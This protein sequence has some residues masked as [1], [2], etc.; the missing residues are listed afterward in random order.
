MWALRKPPFFQG[1]PRAWVWARGAAST[2]TSRGPKEKPEAPYRDSV[3]LPRSEFP[4]LLPG[5]LQPETEL[6]IQQ[7]CGFSELYSWQRQRKTKQ[8]FCLH[9]GPPYANGD[10]HV[11]HALNKILKDITNRFQMM[12]GSVVHYVPGWDCHGLPIELR[13]LSECDDVEDLSPMEIRQKARKFAKEA[14]AKQKSAF[15]RWGVMA[16]W[17]NCYY[18]FDKTYEAKQL[19]IFHEIYDKGYVY[20]DY[21][22]VFGLLQLI[23]PW[24]KLNLNTTNNT[25]V[26]LFM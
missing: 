12:R 7:K 25:L 3:L 15:I 8:K 11:G 16:D 21:K 19:H 20:R 5:R 6:E 1:G 2:G 18:T 14:I 13:A 26:V 4:A 22:P 17:D 24:P 10:P 9:D 23:Q